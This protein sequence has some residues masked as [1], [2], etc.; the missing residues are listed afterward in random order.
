MANQTLLSGER[1]VR[2]R[3]LMARARVERFA[4]G[5]F[6]AD[7]LA[8]VRAICRAADAMKAPVLIE[9]SHTEVASI[10]HRNARS[11]VDN[12]IK[13]LGIE[14]YL[15]LD[16]APTVAAA[17]LGVD[18]GFE[19]VHLDVFQSQPN[20]RDDAVVAATRELVRYARRTGAIV[21]G[22][23]QYLRGSSSF[24]RERIDATAVGASLSTPEGVAEFVAGTG[25]DTCAV[26]IGNIHGR[27]REPKQLDLDLLAR[28]RSGVEVNLS[29]H[30]GSGTPDQLYREVARA[31]ITK[32]NINSDL[33]FAYRTALEQQ[34]ALHRDEYAV[35]KL[36]GPVAR[37]VQEV[38]QH[39]IEVF[40][41]AGK[42]RS[43]AEHMSAEIGSRL[44]EPLF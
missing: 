16:H 19:F 24:H 12:E 43:Y 21:E 28:I 10:G 15:N 39:K 14:A 34:L 22:E 41:S 5:A 30:G 13:E 37:A 23:P 29:L 9:L 6:N 33:R 27:Y 2:A 38:V 40:G 4:V 18:A 42:A 1:T 31:G 8:T 35:A 20:A 25:V 11:I 26:G 32:I 36:L 44:S 17:R 7:D 3:E